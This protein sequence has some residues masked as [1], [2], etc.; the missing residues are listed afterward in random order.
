MKV[1]QVINNL[2][3]GGAEKL[4]TDYSVLLKTKGFEVEVLLLF[5]K[6]SVYIDFLQKH[7]ISVSV[8]GNAKYS[9]LNLFKLRRFIHKGNFD[10]VHVHLFPCQYYTILSM[11]GKRTTIKLVTT[12]HSTNNKRRGN[13]FFHFIERFIYSKYDSVICISEKSKIL[14]SKHLVNAKNIEVINNGI[15]L[16]AISEANPSRDA[17]FLPANKYLIMVSRF[18]DAKD[19][20]TVINALKKLPNNVHLLLVG[21]GDLKESC[22]MYTKDIGLENRVSFLGFRNDVPEL[23]K[24]SDIIV[25]SS[26]W[27]GLSLA[28]VEGLASGKP[29]IA[30]NVDGLKQVVDGAGILFEHENDLDLALKLNKLLSDQEYYKKVAVRCKQRSENYNIEEMTNSYI[31]VYES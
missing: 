28:S 19:Q 1:L 21:E 3:S 22:E 9:I 26:H 31:N 16:A 27:E 13:V 14:L 6:E 2:S 12:E 18:C 5:D 30:S 8:L 25:L 11:I 23:L 29:F 10:V 20:K 17:L 4:V 24:A 7:N 15:N